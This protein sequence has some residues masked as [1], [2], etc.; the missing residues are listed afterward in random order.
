MSGQ[1]CPAGRGLVSISYY[2]EKMFGVAGGDGGDLLYGDAL[3][4]CEKCGDDGDEAALVSFA[5]VWRGGEV[6]RVGLQKDPLKGDAPDV[7]GNGSPLECDHPS[8]AHIPFAQVTDPLECLPT[9]AESV[10]RPSE[11]EL[12]AVLH[13]AEKVLG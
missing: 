12:P 3:A 10:Y 1:P 11:M 13:K 5:P 7:L 8:D 4:F 9:P 6:G 2:G